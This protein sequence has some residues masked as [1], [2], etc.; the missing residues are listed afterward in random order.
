[1]S[2]Y[3][4]KAARNPFTPTFGVSPPV[5]VGRADLISDFVDNLEDGPGAPGRMTLYTGARG[6][7]KT[8][9]LNEVEDAARR[10]GWRVIAETATAGLVKRMITEHLPALLRDIDSG[11]DRSVVTGVS[12][13]LGLVGDMPSCRWSPR[14]RP[15]GRRKAG[16]APSAGDEH[17]GRQPGPLDRDATPFPSCYVF[18]PP[19]PC[20]LVHDRGEGAAQSVGVGSIGNCT[21]VRHCVTSSGHSR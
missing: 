8:V 2:G 13:P 10:L 3:P 18:K 5:L 12:A 7:G 9:M 6:T 15:S 20:W 4:P 11:S 1:M 17:R 14:S 21:S 16:G 19:G